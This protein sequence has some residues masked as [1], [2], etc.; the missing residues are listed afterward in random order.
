ML[1]APSRKG[2]SHVPRVVGA[3]KGESNHAAKHKGHARLHDPRYR[4]RD[5]PREGHPAGRFRPQGPL[6][7]GGHG[8]M[9]PRPQG[10]SLYGVAERSGSAKAGSGGQSHQEAN[11]GGA[12]LR[13]RRRDTSGVRGEASRLLRLPLLLVRESPLAKDRQS[14]PPISQMIRH[15]ASETGCTDRREILTSAMPARRLSALT[16]SRVT[17]VGSFFTAATSMARQA[18]SV[19]S[20]CASAITLTMPTIA[21]SL[22]VW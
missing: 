22:P 6:C 13:A 19:E 21:R 1:L 9:A 3:R 14:S 12:R 8:R 15:S 18:E 17:G 5:R 7:G 10:A 16:C 2:A 11:R 4:R 20:G